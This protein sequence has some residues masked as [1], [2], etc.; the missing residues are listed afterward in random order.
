MAYFV[1][2]VIK[3]KRTRPSDASHFAIKKGG[4]LRY[5]IDLKNQRLG[6]EKISKNLSAYSKKLDVLTRLIRIVPLR[7]LNLLEIGE[8]VI[9]EID[10]QILGEINS[11][12][13]KAQLKGGEIPSWNIIVGSYVEKQKIVFQCFSTESS[14]DMF[15]KVGG[16]RSNNE[17]DNE[18]LYLTNPILDESFINPKLVYSSQINSTWRVMVTEEFE[19]KKVS[20][21]MTNERYDIYSAICQRRKYDS[22]GNILFFS[23]GDFTPWNIKK[24]DNSYVVFDWEYSAFRFYGFD[25]LHFFWQIENKLN[26]KDVEQSMISAVKKAKEWDPALRKYTDEYLSKAYLDELHKQF[27]DIL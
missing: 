7:V 15:V 8:F 23:H 10:P 16:E 27:G 26:K 20:P 21:T 2:K 12:W 1:E 4:K 14:I 25:I 5:L 24:T 3:I 22:K 11:V 18:I 19:G 17:M 9:C 13:K 6:I